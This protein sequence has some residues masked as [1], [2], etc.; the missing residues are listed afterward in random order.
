[1]SDKLK[2]KTL[3][4]LLK[5]LWPIAIFLNTVSAFA[6][7]T[8]NDQ[9]EKNN[10]YYDKSDVVPFSEE[11][12]GFEHGT[13][14]GGS[15]EG[16]WRF[17]FQDYS[18]KEVGTFKY[19]KKE[20]EW[21]EFRKNGQLMIRKNFINGMRDGFWEYFYDNGQLWYTETYQLNKKEGVSKW[22]KID[23]TI[24]QVEKFEN[25]MRAE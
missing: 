17:Y 3:R 10:L 1:M 12:I 8:T 7:E 15:R 4:L 13:L 14:L 19:G 25:N 16:L 22:Y 21:L 20:G 5:L 6:T 2:H 24:R 18:L 11:I 23:G 9:I